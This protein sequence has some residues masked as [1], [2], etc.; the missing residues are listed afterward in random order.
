MKKRQ[1]DNACYSFEDGINAWKA[2][3][4]VLEGSMLILLF[5][6]TNSCVDR[7][8]STGRGDL[9]AFPCRTPIPMFFLLC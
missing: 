3:R 4:T 7:N 6:Q 5:F 2:T 1:K 9:A 8:G